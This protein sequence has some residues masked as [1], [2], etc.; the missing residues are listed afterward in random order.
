[1]RRI[2]FGIIAALIA[3]PAFGADLAPMPAPR[4]AIID[5]AFNWTGFYAG[6]HAGYGWG[7]TQD[8]TNAGADLRKLKGGF[9]GLQVGYNWQAGPL[10][11]GTEADVSFGAVANS[12]GGTTQFDPYYGKDAQTMS[13]TVRGRIGYAFD[14]TLI[15]A[16]GGLAWAENEHGFGCD[17]TRVAL[18]NGCQNKRGG[19]AFYVKQSPIDLGYVVGGGIEY[20]VSR[21]W[22]VKAEYLYA[23]YGT[24]QI[25]MTDPNY[26]AAKSDRNFQ[27]ATQSAR[28]GFNYRF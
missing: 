17:A 14:R 3:T 18:T 28:I 10:V 13:G 24:N 6:L 21:N 22:S 11:I 5:P 2:A 19:Q 12:W 27:T 1:M 26:P 8:V 16:T 20:A 25:N 4:P 9:G 15:Y 23:D 7:T